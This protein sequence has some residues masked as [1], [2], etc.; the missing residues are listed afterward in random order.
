[1]KQKR[2]IWAMMAVLA[3]SIVGC[4]KFEPVPEGT[5][6]ITEAEADAL[7][8][9]MSIADFKQTF[10]KKDTL[11]SIN[12]VDTESDLY[13]RGRIITTDVSGNIYK[14]LVIQDTQTGDALKVSVDAG[15]LSGTLP[16]GQ[17]IAIKCN[18]LALGRYADMVQLGVES[19]NDEK[20]RVEPGRV[21]Y[22]YF[23][24]RMQ[25]IGTPDVSKIVVDTITIKEL[26]ASDSTIHSKLVC[27][28]NVHFTGLGDEGES[29][30][31]ADRL[32]GRGR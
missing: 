15:S 31:D 13:I 11:F 22:P 30:R 12:Y 24:E 2:Y 25:L 19:F 17:E 21:P 27:I 32:R 6:V 8:P 29:L 7:Y 23:S 28:K 4:A 26:L 1:M 18:G 5:G 3:M 9:V 20:M 14:Y 10:D 16:M